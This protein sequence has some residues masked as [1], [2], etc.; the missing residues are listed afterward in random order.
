[1]P[2]LKAFLVL[3]KKK[4]HLHFFLAFL[5]TSLLLACLRVFPS[6]VKQM[7][8]VPTEEN[9]RACISSYNI[10]QCNYYFKL[11]EVVIKDHTSQYFRFKLHSCQHRSIK[12][13]IADCVSYPENIFTLL[14]L[15]RQV[16]ATN[17]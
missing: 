3:L 9:K 6:L 10:F 14:S 5:N 2:E 16:D 7:T 15:Q 8:I 1:M 4:A 13:I 12:S 11:F 17:I